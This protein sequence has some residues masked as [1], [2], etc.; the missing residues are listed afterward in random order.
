MAKKDEVDYDAE[1]AKLKKEKEAKSVAEAKAENKR[2]ALRAARI[3]KNE[4]AAE[5]S[6]QQRKSLVGSMTSI[7]KG[8]Q[9]VIGINGGGPKEEALL[10]AIIEY[11]KPTVKIKK[12]DPKKED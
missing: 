10:A 2:L 3:R 7:V 8:A 4:R 11:A 1:I 12:E 9:D 5:N 6:R